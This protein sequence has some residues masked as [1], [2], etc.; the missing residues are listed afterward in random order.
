MKIRAH[1]QRRLPALG[2]LGLAAALAL[3]PLLAPVAHAADPKASRYYEDALDRYEKKDLP[4]AIIQL[5]N[6][7]QIDANMLPVQLLLGKALLQNGE[8]AAAEVAFNE[9][10]RLGVNRAEVVIPLAQAVIG[11]GKP[12][13][14]F[15]QQQFNPQ[16]L[17]NGVQLQ[18]Q[19]LRA[20]AYSDL[21][22]TRSA[23]RAID[24]ARVLDPKSSDAWLAEVPIR[25]RARQ[26]REAATAVERAQALSPKSAEV[27]YQKGAVQHV[28]GDLKGALES[29]SQS[30]RLD[31][32]H[33]EARVARAGV[34]I[35]LKQVEQAA[36][37]VQELRTEAAT[38]PRGAYLAAL[39][40]ER[41][42]DS[43]AARAAL[44]EVTDL[45]DPVPIDFIRFRPQLLMLNGIAHFSLGQREKAKPYLEQFQKAQS[46]SPVS[47]LLAQIYLDESNVARAI[48][49]LEVY[50]RAQP[51]DSQALTLLASAHMAQGRHARATSLMQ[52][53][54]KTK[55]LPELRTT[56]GLSLMGSGQTGNAASELET[57][58][59]RDPGQTRAGIALVG[60][61]LR[62]SQPAKAAAVATTL[63]QQ[64][65]A[66]PGFLNLLGMA[67][68]QAAK[69]A[70]ARAAFEKALK[71]DASFVAA[72]LNLARL[73]IASKSYDTAASRLDRVLKADDKNTEAMFESAMLAARRGQAAETQRW[74][75]KAND[76][77]AAGDVRPG[78]ALLDLHLRGG[79]LG[80]ALET[81]KRLSEKAPE[82][83]EVLVALGRTQLAN[84]DRIAAKSTLTNATRFADFNAPAQVEI[85]GLQ[86][87][88]NNLPGA[89]YSLEK[90]LSG[91]PDFVPAMGLMAEVE[92]RQKDLAKAEKWAREVV[93]RSP[94]KAIGY[95]LQGDVARARGQIPASIEA[96]RRAHQIEPSTGTVLKLFRAQFAQDGGRASLQLGEQWV[97]THPDDFAVRKAIAD[98]Y[99]GTGKFAQAKASYEAILK[100]AP[101]DTEVMNN[102]ANVLMS[103]SDHAGA[104]KIAERAMQLAPNNADVIDTLGWALHQSQQT[105][106]ALQLLRDARLRNPNKPEIRYH[107]AVVLA[108]VGRKNEA[109]EELEA[110]LKSGSEF[111]NLAAANQLL[112]TLK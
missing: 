31:P 98:G 55:D 38:E 27:V 90:A 30:L 11:Q 66:N 12:K 109:R 18:L 48:D 1:F 99:A 59:R 105:D 75:E 34:L 92:L 95:L 85:A 40:A 57:A 108:K 111:E 20:G 16:G 83:L 96:Y 53:A 58:W 70:E 91:Q 22:D 76:V 45:L 7:L 110:A 102:L 28:G 63:V 32:R 25:I 106:R 51:G 46:N 60:L 80:P 73:D 2:T 65:P 23:Q 35:D 78:L 112:T 5:K 4:G 50:A 100:L 43:A 94:R 24:E 52:E 41:G 82:N 72:D 68:N 42:N 86:I 37:D 74:L 47:K 3:Q 93:T 61:Y 15:E 89:L 33:V 17:P 97:K 6:A 71:A 104:I 81:A 19:L 44:R 88:A 62:S 69:P 54:L 36:R 101:N 21:G 13:T 103:Q 14:L 56:L 87:A 64:Q 9:A 67:Q 49:V 79:R 8:V 26:L 77:A 107:L 39:L 84:A 29:Y 10:L